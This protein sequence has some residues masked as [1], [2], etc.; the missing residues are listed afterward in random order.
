M[1]IAQCNQCGAEL[2]VGEEYL[3]GDECECG[4]DFLEKGSGEVQDSDLRLKPNQIAT[5]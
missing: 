4:G 2:F 5:L 3:I 1:T